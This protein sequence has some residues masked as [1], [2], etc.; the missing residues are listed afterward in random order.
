M[1]GWSFEKVSKNRAARS[2]AFGWGVVGFFLIQSLTRSSWA[3]AQ[4]S[5]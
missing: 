4:A 1:P 2:E 3:F 5:T